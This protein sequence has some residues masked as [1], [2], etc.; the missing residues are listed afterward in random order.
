MNCTNVM[1]QVGCP[2]GWAMYLF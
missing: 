2:V 1:E